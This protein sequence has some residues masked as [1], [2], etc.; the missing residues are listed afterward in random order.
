MKKILFLIVLVC[1][2]SIGFIFSG[3]K[4]KPVDDLTVMDTATIIID[5]D[6][7]VLMP[8][9]PWDAMLEDL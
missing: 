4:N 3:C 6:S 7:I 9:L 5:L 2:I 1:S 8:F